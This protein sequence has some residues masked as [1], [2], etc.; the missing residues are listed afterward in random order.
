M[1]GQPGSTAVHLVPSGTPALVDAGAASTAETVE[2]TLRRQGVDRVEAV[3]L[4]HIHLD[5]AG[6]TGDLLRAFPDA[7]A[8]VPERV[9][10][11]LIDPSRL[12]EGVRS[13]WGERTEELFGLPVPVPAERVVKVADGDTIELGDRTI[14]ALATPGHTRAHLAYLDE[15]DG[16]LFCGDALGIHLPAVDVVRPATPPA[17]FSLEDSLAS[18]E[19]IREAGARRLYVAHYGLLDGD[20]GDACDRATAALERWW[21]LFERERPE[22]QGDEDLVRRMHCALEGSIEPVRPRQRRLLET[23]NPTWLNVSGMTL[24]AD[25]V[26]S[27]T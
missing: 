3:L 11:H 5:H 20:P 18:I 4:T 27:G 26:R 10:R 22:A 25:R 9:A 6:G 13:V 1:F 19:R 12:I 8:Y 24:A 21:E 2:G 16:S 14:V 23:V 17:D 15:K 7:K